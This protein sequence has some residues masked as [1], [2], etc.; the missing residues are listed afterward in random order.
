MDSKTRSNHLLL[1]SNLRGSTKISGFTGTNKRKNLLH[2][3]SLLLGKSSLKSSGTPLK[4]KDN[5]LEKSGS[6]IETTSNKPDENQTITTANQSLRPNLRS[7]LLLS[8]S[9]LTSRLTLGG[10]RKD[11]LRGST[12]SSKSALSSSLKLSSGLSSS[13]LSS[14]LSSNLLLKGK[15]IKTSSSSPSYLLN[16]NTIK[17]TRKEKVIIGDEVITM[18]TDFEMPIYDFHD[19]SA[20]FE[21]EDDDMF[22]SPHLELKFAEV[23]SVDMVN[24]LKKNFI[25]CVSASLIGSTDFRNKHDKTRCNLMD[26]ADCVISHDAEFILKVALYCRS[27]L[28]IRTTSNFLIAFASNRRPCRAYLKK[29][30]SASIR[31]PSDWIDV[32]ETYQ[33]LNDKSIN[34]GSLPSALRKVMTAKFPDFDE[35]QL[36]KYNKDKKGKPKKKSEKMTIAKRKYQDHA[37]REKAKETEDSN[38]EDDEDVVKDELEETEEELVKLTFTLK[39]LIRKLHIKEPANYVMALVGKKYPEDLESFYKAKLTGVWDA[40]MAGKRMKLAIPETWETQV[41]KF[42]NK[43]KTWERLLD[44]KK[45]PFMAMLRNLRNMIQSGM[46]QKHH[47]GVIKRLTNQNAVVNSRQF[48]FRFFSAYEAL[49]QLQQDLEKSEGAIIKAA[50]K[51]EQMAK[52][53]IRKKNKKKEV[54][55]KEKMY[56]VLILERYRKALDT[57]VKIATSYNVS[58]IPGRTMIFLNVGAHMKIP[59]TSA[60]GLGRP[61]SVLEVGVLLGLMCKYSCEECTLIIYANGQ[62]MKV[63]LEK[64]TILDNMKSV[65]DCS[66]VMTAADDATGEAVLSDESFFEMIRDRMQLDNLVILS[67]GLKMDS[68]QGKLVG[69]FLKK[70]RKIVNP[71]LLFVN[72]DLSR[73]SSGLADLQPENENDIFIAGYSD[74][75][76]RYIAERGGGGQLTHVENI[77][78]AQKLVPEQEAAVAKAASKM[79]A[80]SETEGSMSIPSVIKAPR[81]RTARVFISSTFRDMHGERDILTRCV[82]PELRARAKKHHINVYEVD[83]RWGVTEQEAKQNGSIEVCLGEVSRSNF[84]IGLLG[85]R[86]GY[87]PESYDVSKQSEEFDWLKDYPTGRSITELEMQHGALAN[88]ESAVGRAFFYFRTDAIIDKI[89]DKWKSDFRND[90]LSAD[91]NWGNLKERIRK[92]PLEVYD[93]YPCEWGGVVDGKPVLSG[94]EQFGN[95]VVNNLWQ[96][97]KDEFIDFKDQDEEEE[98][99]SE[100]DLHED[101]MSS[102]LSQF[103][104]RKN[105]LKGSLIAIKSMT[106]GL[107]GVVGKP[108][109]GKSAF[110]ASLAK[111]CRE[112]ILEDEHNMVVV[113]YVGAAPGNITS[114]LKHVCFQLNSSFGLNRRIPDNYKS[115][116][117]EFSE[118]LKGAASHYESAPVKIFIDGVDDLEDDN[119]PK[120]LEW[121]P[122]NI[123]EDVI[124]VVS[125]QENSISHKAL[126]RRQR[127]SCSIIALPPLDILEKAEMIRSTLSV[128]GKTLDESPFNNQLKI[129]TAKREANLPLYLSLACEEIRLFGVFEELSKKLKSMSQTVSSLLVDIFQRLENDFSKDTISTSLCLLVCA[130]NGLY[131][132]ELHQLLSIHKILHSNKYKFHDVMNVQLS[133]EDLMPQ[134]TYRQLLRSLQ[135]FLQPIAEEGLGRLSLG[136][137]EFEKA[138]RQRYL[139]GTAMEFELVLHRLLAAFYHT[140]ADPDRNGTWKGRSSHTFTELPYHLTCCGMYS[141]L[142]TTLCN[143]NFV[144]AKCRLGLATQLMGD[145][146]GEGK[147][148]SLQFKREKEKFLQSPQVTAFKDFV[149]RNLHIIAGIPSLTWQQAINESSDSLVHQTVKPVIE[150]LDTSL[151]KRLLI[152]QNK[153]EGVH[154]CSR[155]LPGFTKDITCIS[156]SPNNKLVAVGSQDCTVRL[157]VQE[158]GMELMSFSGHSNTVSHCCFVG[159][160]HLVSSSLD[161]TLCLWNVS[162]GH[163][164][165]RMTK[166]KRRVSN[167]VYSAKENLLVSVSWDCMLMVWSSKDGSYLREYRSSNPINCAA[168]HPES[169]KVAFGGWDSTIVIIDIVNMKRL[170]ILRG[171]TSAI[172]DLAYSPSGRHIASASLCGAV[173][174]WSADNGTQVGTLSGHAMPINGLSFSTA[175]QELITVSDDQKIK[176]WSGQLGRHVTTFESEELGGATSVSFS[177]YGQYAAAGYHSGEVRLFDLSTGIEEWSKSLYKERVN[178]VVWCLVSTTDGPEILTGSAAGKLRMTNKSGDM[179]REL[180]GAEGKAL[181]AGAYSQRMR[182]V[183]ATSENAVIYLWKIPLQRPSNR[184]SISELCKIYTNC[185]APISCVDFNADGSKFVTGSRDMSLLV[186]DTEKLVKRNGN[187]PPIK[188]LNACHKDWINCCAWS[189]KDDMVVTGS[190]DFTLKLWD[191]QK[192]EEVK[193]EFKGHQSSVNSVAFD[194]GCIVSGSTDGTVKVWSKRGVEIT[195]INPQQQRINSCNIRVKAQIEETE[196]LDFENDDFS[197]KSSWVTESLVNEWKDTHSTKKLDKVK[198]KEVM[199]EDVLLAI[200]TDGG[201]VQFW[202][203][204]QGNELSTLTGHSDRVTSVAVG[205]DGQLVTSSLDKTIKFW[206]YQVDADTEP[207]Q[208]HNGEVTAMALSPDGTIAISTGRDGQAAVWNLTEQESTHPVQDACIKVSEK[209]LTAT[210]FIENN[211]VAIGDNM[212]AVTLWNVL[213]ISGIYKLR[214]SSMINNG[215][216]VVAMSPLPGKDLGVLYSDNVIKVYNTINGKLRECKIIK[217]NL[218]I[219]DSMLGLK[220]WSKENFAVVSC[221]AQL[222]VQG[223][224][225]ILLSFNLSNSSDPEWATVVDIDMS[226]GHKKDIVFMVGNYS[227]ELFVVSDTD[228]I[229]HTAIEC[230]QIHKGAVT[231]LVNLGDVYVTSSLD[232]TVKLWSKASRSQIGQFYCLA[233]VTS[234]AATKRQHGKFIACGDKLGNVYFLKSD[235]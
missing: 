128:Y 120:N 229:E 216:S 136:H 200:A 173:K 39:Q 201:A 219:N 164:I 185:T 92:S 104:G 217:D 14:N 148:N 23:N 183:V 41:S 166:H 192:Y 55:V 49:R 153:H 114:L 212:G 162:Q 57:A 40:D 181:L 123:P 45:L 129:L 130:R 206:K 103:V 116:C 81:W 198:D 174:L 63:E 77:D 108:G 28:N 43:A 76:L 85:N 98:K 171:H 215:C 1:S 158:T 18:E 64:G 199:M 105:K 19:N 44:N 2:S 193:K 93:M 142:A 111:K 102:H 27:E 74:Q 188:T 160:T 15:L 61:K 182:F 46:S 53:N 155:T 71:N 139:R 232:G 67:D 119:Q 21:E 187:A 126:L 211:L 72:V 97:I 186:W 135:T 10:Q 99:E 6:I 20:D 178:F 197:I 31:L 13:L 42:G 86:Y 170:A 137:G 189:D 157:Y 191:M 96:A 89:P 221:D 12:L 227:G 109:C 115:L 38:S 113:H 51:K 82:F 95:R 202:K 29:Y 50:M 141:N 167:C 228:S 32:A 62:Q 143:L 145:F 223:E 194:S 195:T 225:P 37:E 207:L 169:N 125:C 156:T 208:G 5:L 152:W 80:T 204:L 17:A 47:D 180:Q 16:T 149:S 209:A 35:Y 100:N 24:S 68:D 179:S 90:S 9:S 230:S 7:N 94:L 144:Q 127:E 161:G 36:A 58:P 54:I 210:C 87:V 146:L 134:A 69:N 3:K 231:D 214:K 22:T 83:L 132:D 34:F 121:I 224:K 184:V 88:P 4:N 70:Y 56:D 79:A 59:C 168:L 175:G 101:Y 91:D 124:F 218:G 147:P 78:K 11:L 118:F 25:N 133:A 177:P 138:I 220:M 84:F 48:P 176:I 203:P 163:R 235:A 75:I 112:C 60:K 52:H 190:N 107:V 122:E 73:K 233:P 172:R 165:G 150:N 106:S 110:M 159:N 140:Q 151:K 131:E 154:S 8:S 226:S 65:I 222:A 213:N 30:F 196:L 234:M 205:K 117:E 66:E 26:I 33:T